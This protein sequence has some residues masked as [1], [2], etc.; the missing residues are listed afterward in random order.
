M[1]PVLYQD[2][3][4]LNDLVIVILEH[5]DYLLRLAGKKSP[6][7][8]AAYSISQLQEPISDMKGALRRIKGI[9]EK[10]ERLILEILETGNSSYYQELLTS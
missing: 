1:P 10:S 6:Y 2:I 7:G 4:N 9:G 8:Y 5:I 3:L